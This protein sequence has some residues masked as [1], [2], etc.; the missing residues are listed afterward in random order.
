MIEALFV[1]FVKCG[2][3]YFVYGNYSTE[4]SAVA[5]VPVFVSVLFTTPR[6]TQSSLHMPIL[7]LNGFK[8]W[9]TCSGRKLD[10]FGVDYDYD[11]NTAACW[12][13]GILQS[14]FRVHWRCMNPE[15]ASSG[16]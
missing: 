11:N 7:E 8:A 14:E 1:L 12:I 15:N 16:T 4:I 10:Q 5:F 9:I 3:V 2:P 6:H 13:P